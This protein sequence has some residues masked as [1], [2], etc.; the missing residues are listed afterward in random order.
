MT[1][2]NLTTAGEEGFA[3]HPDKSH[4]KGACVLS[5]SG[6]GGASES[7]FSGKLPRAPAM[8]L[9]ASYG[10]D[11]AEAT[12]PSHILGSLSWRPPV[13]PSL[14]HQ[15]VQRPGCAGAPTAQPLCLVRPL[16]PIPLALG[17][18]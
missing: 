16:S 17:P 15:W 3:V 14:H 18:S 1:D 5:T 9:Q 7:A 2:E 13:S 10:P 6:R 8:K 4:D 11:P 12:L